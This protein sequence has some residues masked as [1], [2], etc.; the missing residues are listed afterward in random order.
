MPHKIELYGVIGLEWYGKSARG[1]L[2]ELQAILDDDT[3]DNDIELHIN[4]GGGYVD[5]AVAMHNRLVDHPGNVEVHIDALA[6][7]AATIVAMAGNKIIMPHNATMMI[8]QPWGVGIGTSADMRKYAGRLDKTEN[9]MLRMYAK[10]TKLPLSRLKQMLADETWMDAEEALELRFVDE[11]VEPSSRE[12]VEQARAE[13]VSDY[14]E[15][16]AVEGSSKLFRYQR[17]PEWAD[18]EIP[19]PRDAARTA[20]VRPMAATPK[21]LS[22]KEQP[23]PEENPPTPANP[24][25]TA[26]APTNAAPPKPPTPPA[27]AQPT[28]EDERKRQAAIR[29]LCDRHQVS[30][31]LREELLNSDKSREAAA[32]EILNFLAENRQTPRPLRVERDETEKRGEA[33]QRAIE[34]RIGLLKPEEVRAERA[35]NEYLGYSM[36]EIAKTFATVRKGHR[37]D[38]VASS[39]RARADI[40][41][42]HT[43]S[44]FPKILENVVNKSMLLGWEEQPE[45]FEAWTNR[46]SLSD[47]KVAKR[48]SLNLF[49]AFVE[50]PEG[51]E[52]AGTTITERGV[53]IQLFTYGR[54]FAITRELIIN[55]DLDAMFGIPRA[56][57]RAARRTV[58]NLAYG[59]LIENP[60]FGNETLFHADKGNLQTVD[61]GKDGLQT[62]RAGMRTQKDPDS[63][64]SLN[65]NPRY[66]LVP[67]AM[68]VDALELMTAETISDTTNV[69]RNSLQPIVEP[70]LDDEN[71]AH[72]YVMGDGRLYDTIEIA[73]LDGNDQPFLDSQ[74]GWRVD[75]VEFKG[76]IDV[77]VGVRDYRAMQKSTGA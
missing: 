65:I 33:V 32:D 74:D 60:T 51:A 35:Q 37:L 5:D 49:P 61:L 55:D 17:P 38:I 47:F 9:S 57:G 41:I 39:F 12:E 14:V 42:T 3:T 2:A 64:A 40:G 73:Y 21:P 45:T 24:A 50:K 43:T 29:L 31:E 46:G 28:A 52:Y 67:A 26:A 7:S 11:V 56:M 48:V 62:M 68:E 70:R 13:A 4:S 44:D 10:H 63:L 23:M 8:H 25:P 1:L 66:L 30:A 34:A 16:L 18:I 76:R 20:S 58:G 72:W 77:G 54:T 15:A 19:A 6:A 53:S 22:Q 69:L 27:P 75:G 59:K 36:Y 71:V